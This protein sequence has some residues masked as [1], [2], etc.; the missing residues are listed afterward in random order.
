MTRYS[1]RMVIIHWLTLAFIIAA[2]FIGNL[3]HDAR[4]DG[5]AE[6]A[7]Y[8]LH[9]LAGASVLLLTLA[10]PFFRR[11]DGV[12][13]PLGNTPMDKVS[14]GIQHML[15]AVPTLLAV[16]GAMQVLTSDV[17]KAIMAGDAGMLPQKFEGVAAHGVHEFLVN[18]LIVLVVAHV[19]GA[20]K[21]QFVMRDGLM[22]R[23]SLRRKD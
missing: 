5:N 4:H 22:E 13:A 10:R 15:Y 1:K 3:V 11:K 14:A 21:H 8:V 6:I 12:P 7:C 18:V 9:A 20:L 23:M 19:L 17:G 16:S 2:W